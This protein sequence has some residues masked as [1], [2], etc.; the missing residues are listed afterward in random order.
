MAA[1]SSPFFNMPL[2]VPVPP[3]ACSLTGPPAAAYR[4]GRD[5][6]ERVQ[7]F[8]GARDQ[9]DAQKKLHSRGSANKHAI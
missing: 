3:S 5:S 6:K 4:G 1:L 9:I 2:Q 8:K 7:L